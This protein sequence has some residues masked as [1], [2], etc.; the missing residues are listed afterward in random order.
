V[1]AAL[2]AAVAVSAAEE[3]AAAAEA[4]PV[5]P[6]VDSIIVL[7]IDERNGITTHF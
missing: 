7:Q 4:A 3:A 1:A 5:V 6:G 2:A